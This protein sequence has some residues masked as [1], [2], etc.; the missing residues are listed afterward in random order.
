MG[1]PDLRRPVLYPRHLLVSHQASP[2]L[3][4]TCN[5]YK[6][7]I[8]RNLRLLA[9]VTVVATICELYALSVVFYYIFKDPLPAVSSRP[10]AAGIDRLPLFFG[11]GKHRI[12]DYS[13]NVF[14]QLG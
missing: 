1:L 14:G 5:Q 4:L 10:L 8:S 13:P 12:S 11:T 7:Y 6:L 9:P 2:C 3:T